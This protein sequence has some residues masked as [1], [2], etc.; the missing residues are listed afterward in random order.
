MREDEVT[1]GGDAAA[2]TANAPLVEDHF[3]VVPKVV[4]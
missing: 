1:S 3:Y 4:E 2:V